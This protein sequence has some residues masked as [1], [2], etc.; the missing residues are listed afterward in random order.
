ML[1][2]SNCGYLALYSI[3]MNK[4]VLNRTLACEVSICLTIKYLV[5]MTFNHTKES[6]TGLFRVLLLPN[7]DHGLPKQAKADTQLDKVHDTLDKLL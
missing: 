3:D 6:H 7:L 2:E 1:N 5:R 4:V